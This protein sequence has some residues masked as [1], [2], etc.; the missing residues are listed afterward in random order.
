MG[1]LARTG[2]VMSAAEKRDGDSPLGGAAKR[3]RVDPDSTG[4]EA[5]GFNAVAAERNGGSKEGGGNGAVGAGAGAGGGD[6]PSEHAGGAAGGTSADLAPPAR[7]QRPAVLVLQ[8]DEV[9]V[10]GGA[11]PG[12][13]E[14]A[15]RSIKREHPFNKHPNFLRFKLK[16]I[17]PS[18]V[19]KAEEVV[20]FHL[21]EWAHTQP[22]RTLVAH[23]KYAV[24]DGDDTGDERVGDGFAPTFVHQ[25]F[26]EDESVVG[27][28]GL[29]IRI[30]V[31]SASLHTRW[32]CSWEARLDELSP[33]DNLEE[34]L[35]RVFQHGA[36]ASD[37]EFAE[38]MARFRNF[39]P[40]EDCLEAY[41]LRGERFQLLRWK[42]DSDELRA[43]H[44]RLQ[45]MAVWFIDAADGVDV[46]DSRWEVYGV[47][48]C[49]EDGRLSIAAYMTAFVF[50]N[51]TRRTRA[52]SIRLCQILVMPP[53]QRMGHGRRLLQALYAQAEARDMFEVTVEDPAE[54][55]RRMRDRVDFERAASRRL[56]RDESGALIGLN[57]SASTASMREA[58]A[59]ARR[60][61]HDVLRITDKQV[62]RCHEALV[63]AETDLTDADAHKQVRLSIKRRIYLGDKRAFDDFGSSVT[64]K[65]RLTTAYDGVEKEYLDALSKAGLLKHGTAP[66]DSIASS[67]TV[68]SGSPAAGAASSTS[69][70]APASTP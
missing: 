58:V 27:Y 63:L 22:R 65:A 49:G 67:A 10:G 6:A 52:E 68:S 19:A 3:R 37:E 5:G 34:L 56:F 7:A 16:Q 44:E 20:R 35:S 9:G 12:L 33:K 14:E 39:R 11:I 47:F 23:S 24:R 62:E 50:T 17:Y 61:A 45:Q 28:V 38:K 8:E 59:E 69:A 25:V 31:C 43:Y 26:G 4:G 54:G 66:V 15:A 1:Q 40:S 18:F 13:S 41:E 32:R 46:N 53:H 36:C 55:F 70:P 51:P 29:S 64:F 42:L 2:G 48:K 21:G 60:K 30:L 57:T